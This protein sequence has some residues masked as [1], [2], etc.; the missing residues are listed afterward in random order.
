[1]IEV[2]KELSTFL[3]TLYPRVYFQTASEEAIYPYI[4]YDLPSIF[5]DGEGGEVITLDIDG[6]DYNTTGDTLSIEDLMKNINLLDKK[7]FT[8]DNMSVVF[9]LET[10]MSLQDNDKNI[11]RRKYT[12]TGK[13][14]RR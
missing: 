14:F 11:K 8:T 13:L 5:C 6:W 2:R 12:Y 10:K 4:V 9:Y 1:M 7:V 3:K